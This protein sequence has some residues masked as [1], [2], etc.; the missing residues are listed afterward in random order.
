MNDLNTILNSL[1]G[2]NVGSPSDQLVVSLIANFPAEYSQI[3]L[4]MK[5]TYWNS[6]TTIYCI[7]KLVYR[8]NLVHQYWLYLNSPYLNKKSGAKV[9]RYSQY[10][11]ISQHSRHLSVAYLFARLTSLQ[12]VLVY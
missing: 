11:C 7:L 8:I 6:Y 1:L 12:L 2:C 10:W 4:V 5:S 9:L 3:I